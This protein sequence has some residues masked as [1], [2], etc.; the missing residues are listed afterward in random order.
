MDSQG[1]LFRCRALVGLLGACGVGFVLLDFNLV[2]TLLQL[3]MTYP[4]LCHLCLLSWNETASTDMRTQAAP[5]TAVP[6]SSLILLCV[7]PLWAALHCI[8]VIFPELS[9]HR[10]LLMSWIRTTWGGG[11][12]EAAHVAWNGCIQTCCIHGS[13]VCLRAPLCMF[14]LGTAG[15]R[16]GFSA[17]FR[18]PTW[19]FTFCL[20][21]NLRQNNVLEDQS[22]LR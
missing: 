22:C 5:P 12:G 8:A 18:F 21:H 4:G 15:K 19:I 14:L 1:S 3:K 9:G 7:L 13:A 16:R 10:R 6:M 2:I 17:V 11:R 20:Y